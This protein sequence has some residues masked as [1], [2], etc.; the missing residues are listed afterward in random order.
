MLK[1]RILTALVV[2]SL[3]LCALFLLPP[4]GFGVAM[5]AV[6]VLAAREW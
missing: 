4:R 1:T 5:L 6:T 2:A 3:V